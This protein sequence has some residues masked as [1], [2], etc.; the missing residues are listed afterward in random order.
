MANISGPQR[1]VRY[2]PACRAGLINVPRDKMKTRVVN[3]SGDVPLSTH[4]YVCSQ[5][6]KKFEIN[7]DR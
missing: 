4:T 5:C 2:C 1:D 6:K 3:R 7:E